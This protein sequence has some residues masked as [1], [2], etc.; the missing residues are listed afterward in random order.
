[1]WNEFRL[2]RELTFATMKGQLVESSVV[3]C[4]WNE[5]KS[6]VIELVFFVL[7]HQQKVLRVVDILG[8]DG[9]LSHYPTFTG[10]HLS[11]KNVRHFHD[12]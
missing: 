3:R 5:A 11:R 7:E 6:K 10:R 8:C 2:L 4:V 1:M 9:K 12:V